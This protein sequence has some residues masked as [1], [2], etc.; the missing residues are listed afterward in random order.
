[1]LRI[2][3]DLTIRMSLQPSSNDLQMQIVPE[4]L[5]HL[6]SI[7]DLE[8]LLSQLFDRFKNELL[9]TL[10]SLRSEITARDQIIEGILTVLRKRTC[11]KM[12]T[13]CQIRN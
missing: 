3:Q 8:I 4:Q 12:C 5:Q 13:I 11:Q 2:P 6:A 7:S 1:M 9:N 10:K